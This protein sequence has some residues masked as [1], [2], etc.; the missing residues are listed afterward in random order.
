MTKC[1]SVSHANCR[2]AANAFDPSLIALLL[3]SLVRNLRTNLFYCFYLK[4]PL[5]AGVISPL[6]SLRHVELH[7][8]SKVPG[9]LDTQLKRSTGG[10]Q[11]AQR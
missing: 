1:T 4:M 5:S 3:N 9:F 10:R 6:A 2:A 8:L 11:G 7:G